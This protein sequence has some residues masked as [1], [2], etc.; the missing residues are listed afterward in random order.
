MG[1]QTKPLPRIYTNVFDNW[2]RSCVN[3][4]FP[5]HNMAFMH[6]IMYSSFTSWL[7]AD[8]R[9]CPGSSCSSVRPVR[10]VYTISTVPCLL[11]SVVCFGGAMDPNMKL[12]C[13]E[14]GG[15]QTLLSWCE[16]SLSFT[17]R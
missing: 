9:T 12:L 3:V 10:F 13:D 2:Y 15:R 1:Q 17:L 16:F 5:I 8:A 4:F 14:V 6:I 11:T 7:E